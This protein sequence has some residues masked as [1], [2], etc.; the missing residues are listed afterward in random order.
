MGNTKLID[1]CGCKLP[2]QFESY[3]HYERVIEGLSQ[4]NG[5]IETP[6][7][8]LPDEAYVGAQERWFQ[9]VESGVIVRVIEPDAPYRGECRLLIS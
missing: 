8:R 4:L 1:F 2:T 6:V 3:D 5:A 9:E 7:H